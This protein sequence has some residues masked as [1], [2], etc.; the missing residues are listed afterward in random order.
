MLPELMTVADDWERRDLKTYPKVYPRITQI[1]PRLLHAASYPG[2]VWYPSL[3]LE[4]QGITHRTRELF[5][6]QGLWPGRVSHL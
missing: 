1:Q 2:A 3:C 6:R 5:A 4:T